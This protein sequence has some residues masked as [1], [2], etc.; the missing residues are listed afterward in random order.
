MSSESLVVGILGQELTCGSRAQSPDTLKYL[1]GLSG[2]GR[3]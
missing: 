3:C 2:T 1:Q